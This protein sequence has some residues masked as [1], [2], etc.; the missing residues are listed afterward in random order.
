MKPLIM[1]AL[2]V[3][4]VTGRAETIEVRFPY[5]IADGSRQNVAASV[6]SLKRHLA[7]VTGAEVGERPIADGYR[8]VLRE[9]DH[10][11][12]GTWC[13]SE[14][15]TVFEGRPD[16]LRY[17]LNQFLEQ[18][19]G[20]VWMD[21]KNTVVPKQDPIR[22]KT[23]SGVFHDR[24]AEHYLWPDMK[25]QGQVDWRSDISCDKFIGWSTP[26]AFFDWWQRYGKEHPEFFSLNV[27]GVRG[28]SSL[29]PSA[30]NEVAPAASANE[31]HQI[32]L[33]TSNAEL[34]DFVIKQHLASRAAARN[35]NIAIND[36]A[37]CACRCEKCKALDPPGGKPRVHGYAD[38]TDRFVYFENQVAERAAKL[39]PP[40]DVHFLAYNFTE[41][42]PR[43][44]RLG[45]NSLLTFVPTIFTIED[46]RRQMDGWIAAGATRIRVRP[47]LPQYFNSSIPLGM[48]RHLHEYFRTACSYRET[49][50]CNVDSI[51]AA[52]LDTFSFAMY[53]V[54]KTIIEPELTFE[55]ISRQYLSGFGNAAD[56]VG[57][58]YAHWQENWRTRI[59]PRYHA[60]I[61]EVAF[62]NVG[63]Q[64]LIDA[65]KYFSEEDFAV[66][67]RILAEAARCDL[68]PEERRRVDELSLVNRHARLVFRAA[69][70]KGDARTLASRELAVFR[71]EHPVIWGTDIGKT[72]TETEIRWGDLTGMKMAET[73]AKYDLPVLDTPVFWNF[74]IDP[75]DVGE[76]EGWQRLR[77]DAF[78]KWT[79]KAATHTYWQGTPRMPGMSAEMKKRL[80]SYDGLGWY[81]RRLSVPKDWKDRRVLL[82]VGAVDE[83]CKVWVNGM[84]CHERR[85]QK[86][87]D[88]ARP[89]EVDITK[90]IDWSAP[91]KTD[92]V[93]R[94]EDRNG[95]GGLWRKVY[96]V[97]ISNKLSMVRKGTTR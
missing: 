53:T 38:L 88:E 73:L 17:A 23:G 96:L 35:V 34:P 56:A 74:M 84:F 47:N 25:V 8:F 49:V 55:E 22:L 48:E 60:I 89:F 36:D 57:R 16:K 78:S 69:A 61:A 97:S 52:R 87:G 75:E 42:P 51:G 27:H 10:G 5:V 1:I 13:V 29:K 64:V 81:A 45:P 79:E 26:H 91:E 18:E 31:I 21:W 11:D 39:D 58:Y 54:A 41:E 70:L 44:Y 93:I 33:C 6:E 32:E 82:L 90:A 43:K 67:D 63:R 62:F 85:Y 30:D 15:E 24:F 9:K 72:V 19:L 4:V 65:A 66:T 28:P 46:L 14:K 71:R 2:F 92:V 68:S 7:L 83:A 95:E 80:I 3:T 94:V 86:P 76:K 50:G 77:A 37:D 12:D 40:L 20:I 59:L